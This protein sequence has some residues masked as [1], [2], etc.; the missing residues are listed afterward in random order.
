MCGELFIGHTTS[1]P[2]MF[3]MVPNKCEVLRIIS[4]CPHLQ[5]LIKPFDI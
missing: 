3:H 4:I 1:L 5:R 2:I